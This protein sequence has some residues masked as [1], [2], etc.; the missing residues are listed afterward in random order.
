MIF[1]PSDEWQKTVIRQIEQGWTYLQEQE[2]GYEFQLRSCLSDI[3]SQIW[4]HSDENAVSSIQRNL[5]EEE[6]IKKM[7]LY[8][9]EHFV[10]N[11]T[12]S[13]I[14]SAA[15]ISN[16]ECMRC[17]KNVLHTTPNK[18]LRQLRLQKAE[19]LLLTTLLKVEKIGQPGQVVTSNRRSV[20]VHTHRTSKGMD[21]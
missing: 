9:E 7:L 8:L 16:T 21:M 6:R 2:D 3:F 13:D 14:A 19:R 15:Y 10:E 18:Y 20:T 1:R 17:F 5:H 11:I 12:N 4:K